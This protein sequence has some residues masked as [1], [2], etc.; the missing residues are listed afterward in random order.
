MLKS[1]IGFLLLIFIFLIPVE[2]TVIMY[3]YN[4]M[5]I[6]FIGF[7]FLSIITFTLGYLYN[8][9]SNKTKE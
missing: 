4:S 2:L 5:W 6:I 3:Y 9:I 8:F 7:A 1:A